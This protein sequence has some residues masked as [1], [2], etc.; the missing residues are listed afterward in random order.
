MA[1]VPIEMVGGA[2]G[3]FKILSWLRVNT[4]TL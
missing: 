3:A 2:A 4:P 1:T